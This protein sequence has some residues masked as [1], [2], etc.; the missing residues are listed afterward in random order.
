MT[1]A[2]LT[3]GYHI[4]HFAYPGVDDA[5][6]FEAV[7]A[8]AQAAEAAGFHRL[9]VMDHLYQ[10]AP[11]GRPHDPMLESYTTL[12]A[13]SQRTEQL[14]LAALVSGA[15]YRN[16]AL[17][18]K[19]VTALDHVSGGRAQLGIGAGWYQMEHEAF[20]FPFHGAG[21]RLDRLGE[22]LEILT[23]MLRPP[24]RPFSFTGDH[25]QVS[26]VVNSPL[27]TRRIPIIVGGD[28]EKRT[29]RLAAQFADE[30][31]LLCPA[32]DI[33]RKLAALENH[34]RAV[35]RDRTDV[36][37]THLTRVIV[38]EDDR[39]AEQTF[40]EAARAAGM[41]EDVQTGAR[42]F[43]VIGGPDAVGRE[44][45]SRVDAGLDGLTVSLNVDGHRPDRVSLL[46][47]VLA[48]L[49]RTT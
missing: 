37:V 20:G 47:E 27:P 5:D 48:T 40:A 6:I 30:S 10:L 21:T 33:P 7:V 12:A 38:G 32:D 18:A 46:G 8:Q 49:R 3:F 26:D 29:L 24:A 13:L 19:I 39:D 44:L 34:C 45:Q 43:L 14:E 35:G 4:A 16:P 11:T 1:T 2:D 9:H 23:S 15:P 36:R 28:G 22:A 17:L 31:N 25:Y 42:R 41:S